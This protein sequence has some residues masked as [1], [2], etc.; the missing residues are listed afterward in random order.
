L[1]ARRE[2]NTR[3]RS[4]AY[5]FTTL[6]MVIGVI[7]ISLVIKA[8]G[9]SSGAT[10]GVL[11]PAAAAPLRSAAAAVGLDVTTRT[12]PDQATGERQV[13]DG[14]L[15]ALVTGPPVGVVV[16]KNLS[17]DLRNALNVLVRQ[18]ALNEQIVKAGGDPATVSRAVAAASVP[19]RSLEPPDTHRGARI[20]VGSIAI[21]LVFIAL[22]I[23]GQSVAQGVIEEKSSRIVE[24]LLTAIRPWQLMLGK[25]IGIGVTGLVQM[26]L[27]AGA[28]VGAALAVGI[29]LPSS[30]LTGAAVWAVVWFLLGF[31]VY[32]LIFAAMGA[33]VS[34]QE[35]AGGVIAPG[36]I[37]LVVPYVM[38]ISILPAEPDNGLLR[39]LSLIPLFSPTLMPM[40]AALGAPA[41]ELWLALALTVPLIIVLVWLAG[42]V[43]RNAV[44]RMGTR[45]KLTDAL[46]SG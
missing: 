36:M 11:D 40:R 35:D 17:D 25:V 7:A 1:V 44:L 32:A 29:D 37:L 13:R 39:L 33:L 12:V 15:D 34:R 10:I 31:F 4:K 14:E 22:Q 3:M 41:W 38:G 21:I 9:A 30:L 28:G 46:R 45:I 42:R 2:I 6:A 5:L 26:F 16:K 19:V 20:A 8:V 27:T 23:Y 24:I 43:Y 18:Q